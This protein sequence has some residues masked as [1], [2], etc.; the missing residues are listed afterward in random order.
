MIVDFKAN[1]ASVAQ[2]IWSHL[3]RFHLLAPLSAAVH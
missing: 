3:L 2:H 1:L